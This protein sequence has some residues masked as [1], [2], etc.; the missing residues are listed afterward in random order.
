MF[1][2]KVCWREGER[3]G[4]A[5]GGGGTS[6]RGEGGCESEPDN[7]GPVSAHS[8]DNT[9]QEIVASPPQ[10]SKHRQHLLLATATETAPPPPTADTAGIAANSRHQQ[11]TRE[12]L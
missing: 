4:K 5:R 9:V 1:E 8:E 12:L 6:G 10:K 11:A 2:F 3:G 7:P